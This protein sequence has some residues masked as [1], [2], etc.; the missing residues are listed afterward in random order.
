[1]FEDLNFDILN[2]PEYKEDAVR[3]DIIIPIL[4]RLGYSSSGNNKIRRG[5]PLTHPFVYIGSTKRKI[6]II[7]DYI[8]ETEKGINW[9]LDAKAPNENIVQSGNV[10][11]VYSYAI[12][13]DVRSTIYA[14]CNGRRFTAFHISEIEPILNFEVESLVDNWE[15][16]EQTLSPIHIEK[17]F[18]KDFNPDLGIHLLKSGAD[19]D[20][21]FHFV[22]A[23]ANNVAKVNDD[24]F[25][26]YSVLD[27][28]DQTYA[29]SFDFEKI[30]FE[31]FINAVP[32]DKREA[33]KSSLKNA[34]FKMFFKT[35]EESFE[36]MIEAKLGKE[37][38]TNENESYIPLEVVKFETISTIARLKSR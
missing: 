18:L 29:G 11:Q 15:L 6:N 30:K 36:I 32:E 16:I 31:E 14:L 22:P 17:P 21:T 25:T 38:I 8:L 1:M 23:W 13:P 33:V 4:K 27:F 34:P 12:N 7:P 5:I 10:E 9:I 24:L 35:K 37:I 3:E 2:D 26:F 19:I 20:T 28:G